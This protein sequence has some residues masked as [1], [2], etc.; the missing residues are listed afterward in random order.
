VGTPSKGLGGK[1]DCRPPHGAVPGDS[2]PGGAGI[3]PSGRVNS[4]KSQEHLGEGRALPRGMQGN[5]ILA[6]HKTY[7]VFRE[8][9]K[10]GQCKGHRQF[11]KHE[12]TEE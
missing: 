9:V 3:H 12:K 8:G 11:P 4:S 5:S 10:G 1:R 2:Q 7:G 6:L